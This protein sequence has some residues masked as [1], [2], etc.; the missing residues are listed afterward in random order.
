[1]VS[2]S[3]PLPAQ[4]GSHSQII[5]HVHIGHEGSFH[6]QFLTRPTV[7]FDDGLWGEVRGGLPRREV[8]PVHDRGSEIRKKS[9]LAYET[10]K[11]TRD[12]KPKADAG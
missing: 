11:E 8:L 9:K 12:E 1:M 3:S 5:G 6:E 2:G 4:P 10:G 7:I